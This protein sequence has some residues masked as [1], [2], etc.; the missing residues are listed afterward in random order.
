M[1]PARHFTEE[2]IIDLVKERKKRKIELECR[3]EA[4]LEFNIITLRDETEYDPRVSEVELLIGSFKIEPP[5][6]LGRE[7]GSSLRAGKAGWSHLPLPLAQGQHLPS[8]FWGTGTVSP[9]QC[10]PEG[11]G[12]PFHAS[13]LGD[14]A[15]QQAEWPADKYPHGI[16]LSSGLI[17]SP[18]LK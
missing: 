18:G 2:M 14:A 12:G 10:P 16:R 7:A 6:L 4:K 11:T 3:F 9:A 17:Q 8:A 5:S 1:P 13:D 15:R